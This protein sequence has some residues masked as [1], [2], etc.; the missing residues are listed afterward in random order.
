MQQQV[1]STRIDIQQHNKIN[2]IPAIYT[3]TNTNYQYSVLELC[4]LP[5]Y[6]MDKH[7]RLQTI[8]LGSNY[9]LNLYN[10]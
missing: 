7:E 2:D 10:Y 5:F 9:G 6:L 4:Q 1:L 3:I 8:P